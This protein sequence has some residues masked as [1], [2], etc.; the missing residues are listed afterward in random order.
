LDLHAIVQD[1]T[2]TDQIGAAYTIKQEMPRPTYP[3][4][5]EPNVVP[6]VSQMV[7]THPGSKFR[8]RD[9]TV[10]FGIGGNIAEGNDEKRLIA[11]SADFA[12]L[13]LR[14]G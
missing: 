7:T 2:D 10:A 3:A 14:I 12:E 11:P 8:P 9:A 5:N 6:A 1:T 13:I 4:L